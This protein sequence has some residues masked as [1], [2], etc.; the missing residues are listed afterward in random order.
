MRPP[1][2]PAR[3]TPAPRCPSAAGAWGAHPTQA[4]TRRGLV[5][6][7]TTRGPR[8]CS[9]LG[10]A[11][12]GLSR[13]TVQLASPPSTPLPAEEAPAQGRAAQQG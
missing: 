4:G 3:A 11:V 13:L 12:R 1:G 2:P 9:A 5:P 6:R 10:G 8:L 7:G